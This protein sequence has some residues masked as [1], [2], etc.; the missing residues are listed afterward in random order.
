MKAV[1][2]MEII[3]PAPALPELLRLLEKERVPG[4]T[5]IRSVEGKGDRGVQDAQGLTD[6][7]RNSYVLT[8]CDEAE[9]ERL[10]EPLRKLLN[11]TSG[12]CLVSEAMWLVH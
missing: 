4:Y 3:L 9:L 6:T 8:A 5:L 11:R 7:F 12:V 10:K 2:R 1:K